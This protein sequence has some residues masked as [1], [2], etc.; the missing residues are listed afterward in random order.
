M[1]QKPIAKIN[2]IKA[3]LKAGQISFDE[4]KA[5]ASPLIKEMEASAEKVAKKFRRPAPKFSF[6]ALMR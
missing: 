4:A 2:E 3:L 1:Y 6:T 5:L